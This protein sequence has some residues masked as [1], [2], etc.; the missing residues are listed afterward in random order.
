MITIVCYVLQSLKLSP[1]RGEKTKANGGN[2]KMNIERQNSNAHC[3]ICRK[4]A[5]KKHSNTTMNRGMAKYR[6]PTLIPDMSKNFQNI[7]E[8]LPCCT[9]NNWTFHPIF[10]NMFISVLGSPF[11]LFKLT[12]VVIR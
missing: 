8:T 11:P 6:S 9:L 4:F 12:P 5:Y 2:E 1:A 3:I 7:F 10:L